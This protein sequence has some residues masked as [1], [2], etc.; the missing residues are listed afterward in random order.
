MHD[1]VRIRET[2]VNFL[3]AVN[4][5]NFA[6][7][8]AGELISTVARADR[9]SEGIKLGLADEVNCLIRIG[10]QLL[11]GQRAFSALTVFFFTGQCFERADA[12]EL[13]FDGHTDAV[14]RFNDAA[15]GFD[16]VLVSGHRLAVRHQGAVH[17]HGG[18]AVA[19]GADTGRL[20]AAVIKMHGNRD[21]RVGLNR[22]ADEVF[23]EE[24]TRVLAEA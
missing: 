16:V 10:E 8:F 5:Q 9:D 11:T 12:A 1:E 17:H 6:R 3:H 7:G 21:V 19:H 14:S 20:A 4:R 23:E 15:G 24:L 13:A 18:K 2:G 22:G